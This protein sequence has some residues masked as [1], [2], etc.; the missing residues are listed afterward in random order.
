MQSPEKLVGQVIHTKD[1]LTREEARTAMAGVLRG[2]VADADLSAMLVA[3]SARGETAAEIAGFVEAMR[4][5]ALTLP[6]TDAERSV[7]VDTC[8]T[9]G[10]AMT[11][12]GACATFNISTAVA[13]VA[14]AAGAKVAKSGNRSVTSLSGSA[15]VLE[16]LGVAVNLDAAACVQTLRATGFMYLHA[17]VMHPAMKHVMPVRRALGVRTVF[18]ILG[19]L[20]N[21]AGAR[22]QVMGVYSAHLVPL[23]GEALAMLGT[24]HAFVVHGSDGLDELTITGASSV[25]EV[26]GNTLSLRQIAPG[27]V[28]LTPAAITAL[29]GGDAKENAE[30]LRS[31]FAG[32]K[33]PRRDVVLLNAAAVLVA[34]G[35]AKAMTD[36]AK[37]A[38]AAID[39]G[40]ALDVL[41]KLQR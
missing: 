25:A 26:R 15:D 5:A 8:G 14:A 28:G 24:E 31:I 36:G 20:T 40:G 27:D 12:T 21:P 9:G 30:I 23:V 11:N 35:V 33:S 17:P 22:R 39:S 16:A 34:A 19:P 2:E 13:I 1:P 32:E 4:A 38:A 41:A 29:H 37:L 10:D 18:N 6:L 7:L 3:L